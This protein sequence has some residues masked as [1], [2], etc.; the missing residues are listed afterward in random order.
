VDAGESQ[1]KRGFS[2]GGGAANE[3][4]V[5]VEEE[6]TGGCA[7][8]DRKGSQGAVFVVELQHPAEVDVGDDVDV[9]KE[10][11]RLAERAEGVRHLIA[12]WMSWCF[13]RIHRANAA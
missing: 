4:K 13:G 1:S 2:T 9:M 8:L 5:L 3:L 11:R 10:K 6:E 7:R 12:L